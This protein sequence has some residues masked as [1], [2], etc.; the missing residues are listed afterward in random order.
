MTAAFNKVAPIYMLGIPEI[1]IEV[2]D[3]MDMEDFT[4]DLSGLQ[5]DF[6]DGKIKGLKNS[7][8]EDVK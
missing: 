5:F 6:K 8:F 7:V 1:G 3:V 4:F 2:Q